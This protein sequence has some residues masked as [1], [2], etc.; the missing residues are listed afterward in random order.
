MQICLVGGAVRDQLL[1][2]QSQD[3]DWV[4]VGATE[5]D[6]IA[7]GFHPVGR[8]FPVFIHPK[9]GEEYAL[10]RTERKSG[11]G[12][13]G[14]TFFA[15]PDVSLEEDLAR[16]DLT[17][18]AMAQLASGEIVDPFSG[19]RDLQ[20]KVLRHVSSAFSEDPLRVLRVA[21]FAAQF[22]HL[23]FH[24]ASDTMLLMREISESGEL[25]FLSAERVA[26]EFEKALCSPHPLIFLEILKQCNA[27]D[28][29]F[30]EFSRLNLERLTPFMQRLKTMS[31]APELSFALI[32][33]AIAEQEMLESTSFVQDLCLRIKMPNRY[34]D[35]A[36]QFVIFYPFINDF[37]Q[38]PPQQTLTTLKELRL[39][40]EPNTLPE[41]I[42]L[43][44]SRNTNIKRE[45]FEP[46][47]RL[48]Q[49]IRT[50]SPQTFMAKGLKGAE[51]GKAI[52]AAQLDICARYTEYS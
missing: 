46:L 30:S 37:V 17:I 34:R 18:N 1:G 43:Y 31:P 13:A 5:T 20:D 51:L 27:L 49:Q 23:G 6:M 15:S 47:Q 44:L 50:L 41:L 10:A 22:H 21:R 9:T 32:C 12:Y 35:L 19:Q 4:V 24:V 16:R 26:Q 8:D 11:H 42:A 28:C 14:F 36:R 45:D 7:Q 33:Q 2:I 3:R 29:L 48:L 52:E 38:L 40:K 25:G 39:L